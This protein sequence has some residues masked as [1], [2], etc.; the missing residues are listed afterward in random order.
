MRK[1]YK[2]ATVTELTWS[3]LEKESSFAFKTFQDLYKQVHFVL[4]YKYTDLV[5]PIGQL[6]TYLQYP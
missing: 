3:H 6:E 1:L 2:R 4:V 5:K